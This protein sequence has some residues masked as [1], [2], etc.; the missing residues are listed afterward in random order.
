[1]QQ[2]QSFR[3]KISSKEKL[4]VTC[5]LS[6]LHPLPSSLLPSFSAV[7]LLKQKGFLHSFFFFVQFTAVRTPTGSG[8]SISSCHWLSIKNSDWVSVCL[9]HHPIDFRTLM[10]ILCRCTCK[11]ENICQCISKVCL[12]LCCSCDVLT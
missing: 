4:K 11:C 9:A 10:R 8:F 3:L 1:M 12:C 6:S 7:Y 5:K 2:S